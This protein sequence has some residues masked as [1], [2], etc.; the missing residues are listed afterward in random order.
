MHSHGRYG[1]ER[2]G[3]LG[4]ARG[5]ERGDGSHSAHDGGKR[6]IRAMLACGIFA[7][8]F[9]LMVLLCGCGDSAGG[10]V[11]GSGEGETSGP[12]YSEPT[13]VLTAAYDAAKATPVGSGTI[14]ISSTTLGYIAA[15][16]TSQSRC[17]L[18]VMKGEMS[19][20]YDIPSD[21]TPI[22]VPLNM[23]D[24][25]YV[26]RLMQN[27]SGSNYVEVGSLNTDVVLENQFVPF[28]RPNVFC[29]YTPTSQ[30]VEKAFELAATSQNEGDVVRSIYEWMVHAV[31]YDT[32]KAA[33]LAATTGYIPNPDA[34]LSSGYGVCFDYA[35]LAAA[36]FRS[37]GIPC[38]IITGYVEPD[39][40]Y[41]AWN[42][43]YINGSWVTA[44][45]SVDADTW[46][47]I[48]LTFAAAN[49]GNQNYIGSGTSYTDRYVY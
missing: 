41:H 13:T 48:D 29:Q 30:C 31:A 33:E 14:D 46:C 1:G 24:G 37:L 16:V 6:S 5:G 12:P 4:G 27:T 22:V 18:Q 2:N 32:A 26:F 38:Q 28:L 9:A 45:I 15:T 36:M 42:M 43:I 25:A 34:T 39:N 10:A 8:T 3:L 23:G 35:S 21:G 47:R 17:K 7:L 20:N 19:Y 11:G 44:E 40:I 49:D